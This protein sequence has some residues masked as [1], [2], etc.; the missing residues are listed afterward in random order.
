[1]HDPANKVQHT[2]GTDRV[3]RARLW[4]TTHF[5]DAVGPSGQE[6]NNVSYRYRECV[7]R[8]I[9]LSNMSQKNIAYAMP[10]LKLLSYSEPLN[11][12]GPCSLNREST[13]HISEPF[14]M[15]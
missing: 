8:D 7:V 2:C 15:Y 4:D 6:F 14:M 13:S 9:C 1:M 11:R 10:S 3:L 5:L 12:V